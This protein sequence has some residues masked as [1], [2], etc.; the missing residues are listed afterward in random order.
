MLGPL[1]S[2]SQRAPPS[3]G[4]ARRRG[5]LVVVVVVDIITT[6]KRV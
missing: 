1:V 3:E 5:P 4:P 6:M 2:G